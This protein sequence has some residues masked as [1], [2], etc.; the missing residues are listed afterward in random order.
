MDAGRIFE[1]G[2]GTC[3]VWVLAKRA[4]LFDER[5]ESERSV[6]EKWLNKIAVMSGS[7]CCNERLA[8]AHDPQR[9]L[10]GLLSGVGAPQLRAERVVEHATLLAQN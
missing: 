7:N 3:E 5:S 9:Q 1:R 10:S 2:L 6:C 4:H 8:S